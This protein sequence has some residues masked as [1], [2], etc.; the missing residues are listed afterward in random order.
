MI[1]RLEAPSVID[2][3]IENP[4][5]FPL[6]YLGTY[7]SSQIPMVI[8]IEDF[9]GTPEFESPTTFRYPRLDPTRLRSSRILNLNH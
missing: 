3:V 2:L 1:S 9:L 7:S 6:C 5:I 8:Y 4:H